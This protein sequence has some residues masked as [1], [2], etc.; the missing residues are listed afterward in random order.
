MQKNRNIQVIKTLLVNLATNKLNINDKTMKDKDL[1]RVLIDETRT[2]H[3]HDANLV[4]T[5]NG[6]YSTLKITAILS[7]F[8]IFTLL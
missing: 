7:I 1:Y 5:V 3:N 6:M 8:F 4:S 2:Q